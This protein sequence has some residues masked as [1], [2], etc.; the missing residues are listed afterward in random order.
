M[1]KPADQDEPPVGQ[2]I[3]PGAAPAEPIDLAAR[4][5]KQSKVT[6][7]DRIEARADL[8]ITELKGDKATLYAELHVARYSEIPHL[9]EDVRWLEDR[10]SSLKNSLTLLQTS[11]EWAISFNWFSFAL[12]AV[13][14]SVVSYAAFLPP[15]QPSAGFDKQ[16][17]VAT[18]ALAALLIGVIVQAV[19]SYRGTKTLKELPENVPGSVRPAPNPKPPENPSAR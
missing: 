10:E 1:A 14:G 11:Y 9:R 18:F 17:L 16:K 4:A 7:T 2:P 19:V 13:G 3:L 15:A 5:G 12:I 8:L 6:P